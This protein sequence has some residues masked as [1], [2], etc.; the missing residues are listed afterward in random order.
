[1]RIVC[2]ILTLILFVST[3]ISAQSETSYDIEHE[4]ICL[5]DSIAPD[6][7]VQFWR[8]TQ[9]NNPGEYTVDVTFDFG[10]SYLVEGTLLSCKDYYLGDNPGG[11]G[12]ANTL[13]IW[14]GTSSLGNSSVTQSGQILST[15]LTGAFKLPIHTT[16]GRPVGVSGYLAN[17]STENGIEGY[18]G[19]NWYFLPWADVDNFSNTRVP[20]SDGSKL[21]SS[22]NITFDG[23]KFTTVN[24]KVTG[25]LY[26]NQDD[27]GDYKI[28][29]TGNSRIWGTIFTNGGVELDGGSASISGTGWN[30]RLIY[31]NGGLSVRRHDGA[32]SGSISHN[33]ITYNGNPGSAFAGTINLNFQSFLTGPTSYRTHGKIEV[34]AGTSQALPN[35]TY[36]GDMRFWAPTDSTQAT[37]DTTIIVKRNKTVWF[38]GYGAGTKTGT[39]A[40]FSAWTSSGKFIERTAANIVSDLGIGKGSVSTSTDG[41]GDIAVTHGMGT[42]PGQVLIT[43]T[44]TTPY[45]CTVHTKGATTFSVRFFDMAGVA[46]ASTAVTFD[47][48]AKT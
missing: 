28:Q 6:T 29:A 12:T 5:I 45:T 47:W 40:Y 1:M 11:A 46:V 26:I 20:Y 36:G 35:N 9:S 25:E 7:I 22:S 21:T 15:S 33:I 18:N 10:S 43:V 13:A 39:P 14:T 31:A 27:V 4:C 37:L 44:G 3:Q 38:K 41:S 16:A 24:E 17:N 2:T 34:V 23:T 19:G 42:T 32:G 48:I 8:F 30:D